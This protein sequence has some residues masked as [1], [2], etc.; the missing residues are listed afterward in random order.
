MKKKFQKKMSYLLLFVFIISGIV[1]NL[2][3]VAHA[4]TVGQEYTKDFNDGIEGIER[5]HGGG[6]ISHVDGGLNIEA[7][8]WPDQGQYTLV[9]DNNSPSIQDGVIEVDIGVKSNAGRLGIVFRYVDVNNYTM[10][11]YD[12]G[13]KWVLKNAKDG[14]ETEVVIAQNSV[15]LQSGQ[16]YR[17]KL[18]FAGT[19]AE[20][21]I[22]DTLIYS[23]N[24]LKNVNSG[25]IG[26][27][28]WGY[29]D[30]YSNAKY[31]NLLYYAKKPSESTE[32][33]HYLVSFD[34]N[35]IRGWAVERGTGALSVENGKLTAAADGNDSNTI[36]R[37]K[38][39]PLVQDGF[40]E[41]RV[42]VNNHAGRFGLLF[43]YEN[44]NSFAGIGYD[45]G[46]T[47]VWLN[48]SNNGPLPFNKV[49]EVGREYK[50]SIKYAGE[51]ITLLIDDEKVFEGNVSGLKTTPGKIGLRNWGYTGNFSNVTFDY[52]I[53]GEF[54][55][56]TLNPD[57]KFVTYNDAGTYDIPI[58]LSGNNE[59]DRLFV[60]DNDLVLDTDYTLGNNTITIKKEFI[61]KVK[62][63]GDT[64][65]SILFRDGYVTTFKLQVQLPPDG[66]NEYLRDFSKDGIEGIQVVQGNG[67]V[68]IKDGN[69]LFNSN[70]TSILIDEN[71]P[72]LFNSS[73]EF[74]VDPLK[75]SANIGV[76]V[77]YSENGSWTYI[78]Q[79][80]SGNQYGSN[81]YVRNSNGQNRQ[82]VT[83]STRI[84]ANRVKPYK[85]KVKVVENTVTIYLDG[86]EIFNGVVNELTRSRG[87]SGLRLAGGN[88]GLYQYLAVNSEKVLDTFTGEITENEIS[89]EKLKVKLD[90]NFPRVID[91]TY[92]DNNKKMYGQERPIYCV[93]INNKDYVPTVTATF[94]G[95]EAIYKLNIDKL[96]LSFDV[97]FTVESNT[98]VMK[99]E[100]ID[101]STTKVETINFPNHSLVSIRNTDPNAEFNG[102]NYA[103]DDIKVNLT[104]KSDD[105]TYKNTSIAILSNDELA[106]SISNNSIKGRQQVNYQT[107]VVSDHYSTGL[108]TN[109]YLYRGLD[110]EI[111]NEPWTK[112]TITA[113]RN[114]DN[115]VNYQDGAIALRDDISEKRFGSEL[116]NNSYSSVAMNVGSNAQYPFLRIL[117]N[118]KKFNLSTDGF[119]QTIIIKGYQA[120]GHDSQHPDFANISERAGGIKEFQTL[121]RESEKYNAN[122]GVHINHTE[123]YPEAPQY[124]EN[125]VSSVGG[126]S[127]Y[128]SAKQI[129]REND[130]MNKEDGMGKRLED[131][132]NKAPGLDLVY[133][134]V[135]MDARWP[136]HKL[137]S[138]LNELGLA[139]ASEYAKELQQTSVWAHHAYKGG[140]GTNSNLARFVNHQ[141]QDVF[142]GD[143]LFRGN[144]RIGINGWQGETDLNATVKNFFTSQLPFKYLMSYPVSKW[145][146]NI[147]HFGANNEV[148]SK[149]ENGVNVITKD[150]KEIARG[151]KIFIPWDAKT[152]EKIYHWNDS[153]SSTKWEL[154][155]SWSDV[156]TVYLYE[157]TDLGK[158]NETEVKVK[159]NKVTLD[160]KPNTGYIIYKGKQVEENFEWSTGSPIKDMGFD[161][162][163]FDYWTKSSSNTSKDHINIVNNAK[164]NSHIKVEGNNGADA[165]ITQ[166]ATGLVSGQS[167]SASAW[168][169]VSDG[170]KATLSVTTEDGKEVSNY[171]D[172]T[173]VV[174]GVHHT[175]KYKTNY[176]RVRVNFTVPEGSKAATIKLKADGGD[177]NSW[178]N[179]DD[180]RIMKVGL[181]NQGEHYLFEDFENVDFGFGAFV[182]TESDNSH[183]SET[184]EPYTDDTISGK[185]SLKVRSGD[186]MRTIPATVRFKPNTAYKV[187]FDYITYRNQGFT[188]AIKSDKAK[189]AGDTEKETLKVVDLNNRG[190]AV[191]E[192]TTGDYD[193]YYLEVRKN[194]DS[195]II[196]DNLCVDEIVNISKETLK[197]L[198][199]ELKALD[200]K[201][202]T[203]ESFGKLQ[204][205]IQSADV[206]IAND[207][208]TEEEIKNAYNDLN[209]AK[210]SLVRYATT[211]E[212]NE[213]KAVIANMKNVNADE[214]K[215]DDNWKA[216]EKAIS[217]AEALV[218]N[219]NITIIELNNAINELNKAKE[220]LVPINGVDKSKLTALLE[221]VKNVNEEDYVNDT[222][223]QD[224]K[225]D[226]IEA[227]AI[228]SN[229]AATQDEVDYRYNKLKESYDNIIPLNK[230]TLSDLIEEASK[231]NE[232]DYTEES[233]NVLKEALK[234]ANEVL[235]NETANRKTV[236]DAESSLR[237]AIDSLVEG[238]KPTEVFKKHLEIAV[239]VAK[240]VTEAE[241][242]KVVPAVANE[243]KTALVEAE[244]VLL[245][246]NLTQEAID[247]AFDRLSKAMHMLSF[248]KGDKKELI[249][250]VEKINALEEKEYIK[251]TWDNLQKVL[252]EANLVIEDEN[253]LVNEVN[254]AYTKLVKALL[255][256]RLKPSKDKLQDLINQTGKLN[257][258]DYTK[259]SWKVLED[260]LAFAKTIMAKEDATA[261]EIANAE[262]ELD[263]AMK[264]LIAKSGNGNNN[265]STGGKLPATGTAGV[266]LGVMG[267]SLLLAGAT[268]YK[269]KRK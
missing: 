200:S 250:L 228:I 22:N 256:L 100:N 147:I 103:N 148:V 217:T 8:N 129:I 149:V 81:W 265:N 261:E 18:T 211:A 20:L 240:D 142:G 252:E 136:A 226:V 56:V 99:I 48:G 109:E 9:V 13:G 150:G 242:S 1:S 144:S 31:D 132:V 51:F 214:Y 91:Y 216:F 39:A 194:N 26:F 179:I 238:E 11:G 180:V 177:N 70:G 249:K 163:S 78:G 189:E 111:I 29:T 57:R 121:L 202:Y 4:N 172:R 218:E 105:E 125:L 190:N 229:D 154:P 126:W 254:E 79:D 145:E 72:E 98:L 164:G 208:A 44:P 42:T 93:S 74:V 178:V 182:S 201:N 5:V 40:I 264:G 135:Y 248:E 69:L 115:K 10:I 197:A 268:V 166:V 71:S 38:N 19:F 33:G 96:K 59:I 253:D 58:N 3:I 80:G 94:N 234:V 267:I 192:F 160:V 54:S 221:E 174:F 102:A 209:S 119:E 82:L 233:F 199:N 41:T 187:G 90:A 43:R 175:D 89:S 83:D 181:T 123:A 262:K 130:I 170:R 47:W 122:I 255:D 95:N 77:R 243:F 235:A 215:Q 176:Q 139:V 236:V 171:T 27:R 2:D 138:K 134:D 84:Y 237:N 227:N 183:L 259:D 24:D 210:D 269:R 251:A 87:K 75:D 116:V 212:I 60:G 28:H 52:F 185:Y 16:T 245:D 206:V 222:N 107:F 6:I 127:W 184:N 165:M 64:N 106:A 159:N 198:V 36:S 32:D 230:T 204:E 118:I 153:N 195:S 263:S 191:L 188:A 133:V 247:K 53:N 97:R 124:N 128:D 167:Y 260:K 92:L 223:L 21:Y 62:N 241:L 193:D 23:G 76:I 141:E 68:E 244:K 101:E 146:D 50:I 225:Q 15:S 151:N 25:K 66:D 55:P 157:L 114:S 203:E 168:F 35:D 7:A 117:D 49:L 46:G 120:E 213:L 14:V 113:D 161:S 258:K 63:S 155:D 140:Y 196:I 12:V 17:L 186:Y 158:V 67:T 152:E 112:V 246:E 131:L 224:F 110:G 239:S 207:T 104:S 205:K 220:K 156:S 169:E 232:K 30:N 231:Y 85:V 61:E 88:S 257:S 137:T 108:W 86:A 65:I 173:N 73:V 219:T 143:N 266:S 162:H 45:V 37:D 34:D